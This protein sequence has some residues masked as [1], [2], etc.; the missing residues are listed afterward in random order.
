MVDFVLSLVYVPTLIGL[1]RRSD[2]RR[3]RNGG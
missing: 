3:R 2:R 1:V